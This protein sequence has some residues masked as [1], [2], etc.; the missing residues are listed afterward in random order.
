MY[1]QVYYHPVARSY[2]VIL[3]AIYLRIKELKNQNIEIEAD[4]FSL[5]DTLDNLNILSYIQL[6]DSYINGLIKQLITSNDYILKD[7]CNKFMNRKLYKY[8]SVQ[9]DTDPQYTEDIIKKYHNDE[10]LN[11]YYFKTDQ[12]KQVAYLH[13]YTNYENDIN[14]IKIL[15]PNGEILPLPKYSNIINGLLESGKK[16][17]NRIFYGEI[18][19]H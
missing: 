2:E 18:D 8:I 19:E 16:I 15:L 17:E 14:E 7:L 6:D 5:F 4:T 1:W 11:K 13:N 10:V 3:E 12:V 9:W